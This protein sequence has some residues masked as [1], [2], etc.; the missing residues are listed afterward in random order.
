[1]VDGSSHCTPG[2]SRK[3]QVLDRVAS[4]GIVID[5]AANV[6]YRSTFRRFVER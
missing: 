2:R 5:P 1:M 4:Q 3:Q 6:P